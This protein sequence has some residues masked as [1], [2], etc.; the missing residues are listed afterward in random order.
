MIPAVERMAAYLLVLV[1][2]SK[3]VRE[4]MACCS[5]MESNSRTLYEW[6]SAFLA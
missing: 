6:F 3:T 2:L 1:A 4:T 5:T